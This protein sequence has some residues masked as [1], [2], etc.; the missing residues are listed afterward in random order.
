[1]SSLLLKA[2][3][4]LATFLERLLSIVAAALVA[5]IVAVVSIEVVARYFLKVSIS[6]PEELARDASVWLVFAGSAL[7]VR[8]SSMIVVDVLTGALAPRIRKLVNWLAVGFSLLAL[9]LLGLA[10][11]SLFGPAGDATEP[12]TGLPLRWVFL[13][14]PIGVA[15]MIFFTI[16]AALGPRYQEAAEGSEEEAEAPTSRGAI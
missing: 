16:T 8:R 3:D 4:R 15:L 14:L 12:G 1:M 2:L 13:A 5:A 9:V 7:A 6:W 11:S 10:S